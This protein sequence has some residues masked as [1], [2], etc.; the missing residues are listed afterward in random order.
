MSGTV[1]A[2]IIIVAILAVA[3]FVAVGIYNRLVSHKQQTEE[4]WSG[5][6]V[7]LKQRSS[8]IPN[9]VETVKGYATHERELLER[10]T[11]ARARA[12]QAGAKGSSED[13]AA[14]EA[15]MSAGL[16][17]LF[18]VAENYPALK[19]NENFIQL[20]NSL[21]EIE[22]HIQM[23]RRYYNG[24]VRNLNTLIGQFPSNIVA[25][26]FGFRQANYFEIDDP[27]DRALPEVKF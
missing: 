4:G 10:I 19:A 20:Q 12:E 15:D 9:L 21:E 16:L 7:A 13:R 18:A 24:T 2:V 17:R 1:I 14:A 26:M 11:Q 6:D 22:G 8:L 27:N 5:I 3:L 25:G 23:A